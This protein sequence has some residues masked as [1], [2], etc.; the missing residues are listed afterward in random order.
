LFLN[1]VL[2]TDY[3]NRIENEIIHQS[4]RQISVCNELI[5][6]L[7]TIKENIFILN[8]VIESQLHESSKA[9]EGISSTLKRISQEM[10]ALKYDQDFVESTVE[11]I[12]I[13]DLVNLFCNSVIFKNR[14]YFLFF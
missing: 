6:K 12:K 5:K 9:V 4:N 7:N 11:E 3:N 10:N 1:Q 2:L 13:G 14:S 8:P